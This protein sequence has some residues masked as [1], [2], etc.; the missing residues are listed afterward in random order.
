MRA[1]AKEAENR[2]LEIDAAEI[3]FRAERRIGELMAAQ[4]EA[5]MMAA[6]GLPLQSTGSKTDPVERAPTLAETGI[7][8]HLA[9]RARKLVA[10][11]WSRER[12]HGGENA[13]RR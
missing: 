5:G 11:N 12:G 10:A 4:R 3:R 13:G 6:G 9:D 2:Q 8:K 1:Y 7:G